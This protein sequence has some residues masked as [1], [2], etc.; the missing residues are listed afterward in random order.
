MPI[1]PLSVIL[2]LA[3]PPPSHMTAPDGFE[4]TVVAT[5]P[6]VQDP[7]AFWVDPDGRLFFAETE[8]TNH[9]TMDNRS[10]PFWLDDDLQAMT[11]DDR[12]E[13]YRKW[14]HMREGGMAYYR[15]KPDRVR[16]SI[17]TDGDGVYDAF[18]VF[19]GPFNDTLDGIGAGVMRV[20]DEIWYTN[21]PNLWRLVDA[22]GDG[23]AEVREPIHTGFGVRTAL[24][25]HDMHGLVHGPDGRIY[26]SIGDRGYHVR[27]T[28]GR[29]LADP[30]SGAVFRCEPDGSELELF[31]TGL[32]N[33]Q[34]L[35][36]NALGDLFA[37]DNTSDAGD[38]ARIVFVAEDG[39]TGW[40]M[41]Y[42]TL[43]GENQR[44][45][46]NQELTWQVL[47]DDNRNLR[48]AWVLP[49]IAHVGSGPSGLAYYPGVGLPDEYDDS[50]FMCDFRGS[51]PASQVWSFRAV[52]D[53]AGYRVENAKKF[54]ENVLCTDVMFDWHGRV[55][56]SEWASGWSASER[57]FLHAAWDPERSEDSRIEE[58]R[59]IALQGTADLGLF[60]LADLLSHADMRVRQAAQFELADREAIDTLIDV[61]NYEDDQYAR[62]HAIW[63]LGQVAR[64]LQRKGKRINRAMAPVQELLADSDSEVRAQAAKTL[65]D[66]EFD[67]AAEALLER[68]SDESLRVR[69]HAAVTLGK[70][71]HA[72]AVPFMAG[73][74]VENDD[75]DPFLR[76]AIATA[77]WRIGDSEALAEL[78]A[79]PLP[80]V[81]K[82]AVLALRRDRDPSLER[83][84]HDEDLSVALEA[85]RAVHDKPIPEAMPALADL[86]RRYLPDV[87][88]IDP[89]DLR[90]KRQVPML[91]RVIAANQRLGEPEHA[92]A[93]A[94]IAANRGLPGKVRMEALMAL[95]EFEQPDERDRVLGW[96]R[97]VDNAP[98][99][100]EALAEV[101]ARTLP[102][103]AD[104]PSERIRNQA[105][106]LA[107]NHGVAVDPGVLFSI[108]VDED[109]PV[110][111]R[112]TC[113]GQLPGD[114]EARLLA[115]L[116]Q[117]MK[118]DEPEVRIAARRRLARTH[119]RLAE[120]I[121]LEVFSEGTLR[122]QQAALAGLGGLESESARALLQDLSHPDVLLE[123]D[124]G[125][126]LDVL[127]AAASSTHR[128]LAEQGEAWWADNALEHWNVALEGGDP[129]AGQRVV[130][131]HSGAT[132]LRC[133]TIDGWGGEA[134][135][136][137]D[138]VASRLDRQGILESVIAPQ[139]TIAEGYGE[140]SAM[141]NM[142][143]LLTP[144]EIRDIVAYLMTLDEAASDDES[145]AG[146]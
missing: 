57:G 64:S 42:Q 136:T 88:E 29:V 7:V 76:H 65:G 115:A 36:F 145:A 59:T 134:G 3:T 51:R 146:H 113:I 118:S 142:R 100:R 141:P 106:E 2:V 143:D 120:S 13:Y 93:I 101:L 110:R 68:L 89:R 46:W 109:R 10:S 137:L 128:P 98:R 22:D 73:I 107:G 122:E 132:C 84:I 39:E 144:R 92:A 123:L 117:A 12:L 96:W 133:H 23:V 69:Y 55:L 19:A 8:R 32:R 135:P 124:P 24:Y 11:V 103:L 116:N 25:G 131:Y 138:G 1:V 111:D 21:I 86:H 97:P 53:G 105:L 52:P 80:A 62:L 34:E 30:R 71:K 43:E 82:A 121:W 114:D 40:S 104:D 140:A 83:L 41:D 87:T 74:L 28:D 18:T 75:R 90:D 126:Q 139:A 38:Q 63:G 49:P 54:L 15:V 20:G 60:E 50:L 17:D 129:V 78:A 27:T 4:T 91:R 48:P 6:M 45:P 102:S 99:D 77:L 44:G 56:V 94:G 85:A 66:P 47:T 33:P 70:L 14:E 35:A 119:P 67:P 61:A 127:D 95:A 112:V 5:E 81:R 79:H 72:E 130:R 26:W 9:G 37:G 16:S 125:L 58:A 108:A 31:H